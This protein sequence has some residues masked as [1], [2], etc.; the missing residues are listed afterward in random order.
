MIVC[1]QETWL[2]KQELGG[3][4][5]L[6]NDF[7]GIGE[8]TTDN[9]DKI[10]HGHPPG[11]VAILWNI[12]IEHLI[13]ELRFNENWV[14][15]IEINI[16]DRKIVIINVYTPCDSYANENEYLNRLA[17][18]STIVDE[19][20][21]T[22]VYV[23][24]DY[25]AD[26]SDNRSLFANH[27]ANFCQENG[28]VLSSVQMLP[29]D[30]F[31]YISESHHTVSWLDHCVSSNDAHDAIKNIEI[32]YNLATTDHI[33]VTMS[34][35]VNNLPV[36]SKHANDY[37][38]YKLDWS[39][40]QQADINN[41][42][43]QTD[44]LL[45]DINV[46]TEAAVC[47]NIHCKNDSHVKGI[48]KFYDNIVECLKVA[49][50][51]LKKMSKC[52][53]KGKPGWNEHVA[54]LH[55]ASREAFTL[56]KDSGCAKQGPIFELKK[57]TNARFKYALRF[58]KN[59]EDTMR[60][61]SLAS[62]L[63]N[64]RVE[65]FWKEVKII[66]NCRTPLPTNIEGV[67]GSDKIVELF[68]KNYCD[69]FN[70]VQDSR[71]DVNDVKNVKYS[72]DVVVRA[73][74]IRDAIY[75][76]D[77]NKS[78]GDDSI[79]AEHLKNASL[80]IVPLLAICM[81]GLLVH[82][83]LPDSMIAVLLVPVI[84]N[85]TGKI[86]SKDNYRPIALASVL[87]KVLERILLDRLE[88]YLLTN[89]NQYGFKRKHG[90]DMCVFALKEIVA[91]YRS[92]NAT[93]FLCFLDASKAFD[94]VNHTK[95]FQK[96]SLRGVPGYLIR[97]LAYWYTNQTMM[98]RWGNAI[99]ES[100]IV[101]NG[102]RQ[103]GILS[104][105]L[106]NIYMDELSNK[107][108]VCKTG[109][110]IG[111][112]LINHLMYADD[113]VIFCPCSA[114]MQS[115]LK[116]CSEYGFEFDIKYNSTKSNIMI[117]KSK[118]DRKLCFPEFCLCG[119]VLNVCSQ[120]KYLGHFITHDMSDDADLGR[121]CRRLYAQ[122]NTLV[123]KFHICST[124]V[125]VTLFKTYCTPL[126]TAHLWSRYRKCSMKKL[127]VAYNDCMRILLRVPRFLSASQMFVNMQVPTCQAVL[128]NLMYK[129]IC[130]LDKSE[131]TIINV[132]VN[133][134]KSDVRFSSMLRKHWHKQLYVCYDN[135]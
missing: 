45:Q 7:H 109:C 70:C 130:R 6:H 62:K 89:D 78:C 19:L 135:G 125:K 118:E 97:I 35:D 43:T 131:N 10:I 46:P 111:S 59:N 66:N 80:R 65:D 23:V 64:N 48:T 57:R 8:S 114:G 4:N 5:S 96:L 107:L 132:L 128:R 63:K 112:M 113:L 67:V 119:Q 69:L 40:L 31:T 25:N 105:Y 101:T 44:I 99:S 30:S 16:G 51:P 18:I 76:L 133:P 38:N 90:T 100:F 14:V 3:L 98:V 94:R 11:G 73:D 129:F 115:L 22:C 72:E 29:L 86:S 58:I 123:R 17:H 84:K 106:F 74:E 27:M 61:N 47:R 108:N 60:G 13:K 24:G 1:L 42:C 92:L 26:M 85:K 21:T 32:C 104:P 28:F 134:A 39:K 127:T 71:Y 20:D 54:E 110:L 93:M 55:T 12:T 68:R 121:Q 87:S 120:A 79:Y 34:L 116:I 77:L 75:K 37:V 91:K 95:L 15:G 9:R 82:G 41:Y 122:G 81:T 117:V 88:L 56:W 52:T 49:G 33:P 103:G 36:L 50:E 126:Y 102:V 53:H 83:V 2:T 124:E